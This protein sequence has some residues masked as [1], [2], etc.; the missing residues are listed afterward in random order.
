MRPLTQPFKVRFHYPYARLVL[1]LSFSTRV[2]RIHSLSEILYAPQLILAASPFPSTRTVY[3]QDVGRGETAHKII[4][5]NE[6]S[7]H[8]FSFARIILFSQK[9]RVMRIE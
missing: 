1:F 8:Y 7:K 5:A 4:V 9:S 2:S 3:L 6:H